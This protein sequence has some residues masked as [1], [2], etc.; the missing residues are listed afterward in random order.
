MSTSRSTEVLG[1]MGRTAYNAAYNRG[2]RHSQTANASIDNQPAG[3][4]VGWA[5]E[6]GYLD[7]ATDREKFHRRDCGQSDHNACYTE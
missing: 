2:W 6:D 1:R 7:Y 3:A 4:D 5:W